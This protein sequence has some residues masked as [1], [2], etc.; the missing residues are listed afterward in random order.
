MDMPNLIAERI[1]SWYARHRRDLPWRRTQNP[2]FI[3]ISEVMLQQTQ[4][5]TV[6]PYYDRFLSKFPTV[7]ALAEAPLQEVLKAWENLGYYARARHL[8]AAAKE[9]VARMGGDIPRTCDDLVRLPGIGSYTASAVLSIAFGERVPAVDGNVRR[10]L[11]R[12]YSIQEPLDLGGTQ[13]RI[14][15]LANAMVPSKE[16]G[17]F[18]QGIMELGATICRPR[19][20]SCGVCPV[21]E[22]CTAFQEGLQESL[23]V[24]GK[25]RPLPHKEMTAAVVGDRRGRLLIVQRPEKGLLGGLWKFPGGKRNT[26]ETLEAA[27]RRSVFEEVGIG[28]RIA[29]RVTSV[30]HAYTHFRIT[31][32][33]FRCSWRRGKPKALGC[34]HWKWV[35]MHGLSNFPFSKADRKV[36]SAL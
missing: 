5:E 15:A 2:Y 21:H 31:L 9:I 14:H 36:I 18:N 35:G 22:L 23:P 11:S 8:H 16:P 24:T 4:V 34:S 12:L 20:P 1:L 32:H 13:R 10:V 6:I 28:V 27:L 26:E 29:E 25:R 3:W 17:H 19:S 30:E 33:G 7:G